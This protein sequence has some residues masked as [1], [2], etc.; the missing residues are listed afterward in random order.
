MVEKTFPSLATEQYS[1]TS[2]ATPEYNCI[3]W[4]AGSSDSWWW[5]GPLDSTYWPQDAPRDESLDSFKKVF[6]MLGYS[7]C[8]DARQENGFEK[9]ALYAKFNGE[10][11]HAARQLHN[12]RWTSK[13]GSEIDIEHES[14]DS[15]SGSCYGGPVFFMKRKIES[16]CE[17]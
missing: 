8:E 11:T 9:I 15:L 10:P 14:P 16:K 12:G 13:L 17:E 5:P 4:A 3:A 1:K 2:Q 7:S 6:S